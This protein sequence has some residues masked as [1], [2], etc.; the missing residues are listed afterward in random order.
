MVLRPS[1]AATAELEIDTWV[2]SCRVFGRQLEDEAMHIAVEQARA[3]GAQALSARFVPSGR[4]G[5]I[6]DLFRRLGF[7]SVGATGAA[8]EQRW[9]LPLAGYEPRPT[10]IRRRGA[11]P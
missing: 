10:F 2:M 1:A 8:G 5:V 7:A 9:Q 11:R 6:A 3:K 4:N